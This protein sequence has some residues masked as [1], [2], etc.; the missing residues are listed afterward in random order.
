MRLAHFSDIHVTH[1]PLTAAGGFALKR[2]LAVGSY[3][4]A[5]RG[6]HFAGSNDRITALLQDVDAL[7]IDHAICT[8]DL[9]GV[10][11]E[12]EFAEVAQCFGPERLTRPD[13]YTVIPGNH[14]RYIAS[15]A[16]RF[17]RYFGSLCGEGRFPLVKALPGDVTLVCADA[18]RPT[19]LVDSS[20]LIG[21][22][23]RA[24]LLQILTDPSLR[25]RFVVLAFHYGLLRMNGQ[26]DGRTH[27]L[28]DDAEM[29]ELI[30]RPELSLDLVIHGHLHRPFRLRTARRTIVNAGSATDLHVNGAGYNVYDIDAA[31][32]RVTL[33]R[34]AWSPA[35]SAYVE[36]LASPVTGELVT[37]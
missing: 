28:R 11:T 31:T 15:A 34:R 5:G 8:G 9:T 36:D 21:T 7:K 10:S 19:N 23:Q 24:K 35:A 18:A 29:L 2:L 22:A 37:R 6:A 16:G 27:G 14:D 4:V 20:G 17:E 25:G 13:R 1:F 33:S 3:S 32:H 26:R 12:P 30:D